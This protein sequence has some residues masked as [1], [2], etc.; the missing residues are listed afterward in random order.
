[1]LSTIVNHIALYKDTGLIRKWR[2]VS[3]RGRQKWVEHKTSAATA[4]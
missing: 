2:N 3:P 4:V 1:M